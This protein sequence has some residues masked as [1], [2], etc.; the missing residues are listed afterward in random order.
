MPHKIG[1][2]TRRPQLPSFLYSALVA[3]TEA[4]REALCAILEVDTVFVEI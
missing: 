1:T 2:D 3:S 4:C